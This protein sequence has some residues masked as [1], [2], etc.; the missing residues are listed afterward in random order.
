MKRRKGNASRQGREK[1]QGGLWDWKAGGM[2][3]SKQDGHRTQI[4]EHPDWRA[5]S[6]GHCSEGT[7]DI[8][9]ISEQGVT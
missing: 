9:E 4:P 6:S 7:E 3:G 5:K 2:E 8:L 1:R